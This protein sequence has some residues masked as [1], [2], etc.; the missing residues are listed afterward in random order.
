[1]PVCLALTQFD[2]ARLLALRGAE[3]DRERA[4][5]AAR[6]GRLHG[7]ALEMPK[8]AADRWR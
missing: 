8:L 2:Y 6:A 1:M 7:E 4:L 5:R 3:G